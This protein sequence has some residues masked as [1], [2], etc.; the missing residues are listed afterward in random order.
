[1]PPGEQ[2]AILGTGSRRGRAVSRAPQG[3]K[4]SKHCKIESVR[5]TVHTPACKAEMAGEGSLLEL[6]NEG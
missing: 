1:M 4:M 5:N 3:P 2:S 6:M